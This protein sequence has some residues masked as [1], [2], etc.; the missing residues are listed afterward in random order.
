MRARRRPQKHARMRQLRSE[1]AAPRSRQASASSVV[2]FCGAAVSVAPKHVRTPT[3]DRPGWR[4]SRPRGRPSN[5]R[6]SLTRPPSHTFGPVTPVAQAPALRVAGKQAVAVGLYVIAPQQQLRD[7]I[8]DAAAARPDV[9][10]APPLLLC[11][12]TSRASGLRSRCNT[13]SRLSF[14]FGHAHLCSS[15]RPGPLLGYTAAPTCLRSLDG[16]GATRT[17]VSVVAGQ[18]HGPARH[19]AE[20]PLN[21]LMMNC[22]SRRPLAT[23]GR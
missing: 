9:E 5:G 11:R 20:H 15:L 1:P 18:Q 14:G 22:G 17:S 4:R 10:P 13:F 2:P 19:F 16:A 23:Y 6:S 3:A 8:R 21:R 7:F 12:R